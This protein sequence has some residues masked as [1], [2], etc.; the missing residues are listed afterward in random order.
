MNVELGPPA[1]PPTP[2]SRFLREEEGAL[3]ARFQETVQ[4]SAGRLNR[5]LADEALFHQA[6]SILEALFELIERSVGVEA[7]VGAVE[8]E[9]KR[10]AAPLRRLQEERGL[11]P[12]EIVCLL[13]ALRDALRGAVREQRR[14]RTEDLETLDQ[15][16]QLLSRLGIV[17][18][19]TS[20]RAR[21]QAA[22]QQDILAIEYALL[23]ERTRQLAIT[24]SLTGL[25]NF[26][27]LLDRLKEERA[28]AERYQ[29]LL[30]LV[31]FDIDHFKTYNDAHGHPAGNEVLV[32]IARILEQE[33]REVDLAARYG[34]EE[35]ALLLPETNRKAAYE[36]AERIRARVEATAF[37]KAETQPGRRL[38]LSAGVATFPV[39]AE[40]EESLIRRAD[41][42]LYASK[43]A[44]RNR[45]TA[46]EPPLRH[47]F[48]FR[49]ARPVREVALVGSF[50]S[51][52]PHA[53]LM[54]PQ[55]DGSFH[56]LMALNA[57]VYLYKYV[58]DGSEWTVDSNVER[59]PDNYGG[60]NNILRLAAPSP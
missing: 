8:G 24:D 26:G 57:G 54:E 29:R 34:G 23:Y 45:V 15:V 19:E 33:A 30:S 55:P 9:L 1:G 7:A 42:A 40:S 60:E 56:F 51:W 4:A 50:N 5:M 58:L 39:D 12:T 22:V 44:G 35:F 59:Q 17:F 16:C 46:Y 37:P 53:D 21:E 11:T 47:L 28:R 2:L 20:I 27:Y 3:H 48:S 36:A 38:T 14:D 32:R 49:P 18:F 6:K 13:F 43:R 10:L 25:F 52:D 41:A 31:L